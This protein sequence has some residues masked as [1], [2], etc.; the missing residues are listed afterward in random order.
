MK[1]GVIIIGHGSRA[2]EAKSVFEQIVEQIKEEVEYEI[3]KGA[4]MEFAHPTL[5]E[6]TAEVVNEGVEE[7]IIM[8]LFLYPGVHIQEDIPALIAE[9]E[10]EYPDVKFI[11][12]EGVGADQKLAEIMA[13]RISEVS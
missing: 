9:L 8:P 13:E 7:I 3:V 11:L 1:S 5:E 10:A 12:G 2:Q 6:A 4:A